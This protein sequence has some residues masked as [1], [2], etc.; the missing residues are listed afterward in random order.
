MSDDLRQRG[1]SDRKRININQAHEVRYWAE[2]FG[3]SP[4][5][6]KHAVGTVGDRAK[7]VQDHLRKSPPVGERIR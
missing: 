5:E 2:K 1:G 4:Q 3:V 7:R 6:L